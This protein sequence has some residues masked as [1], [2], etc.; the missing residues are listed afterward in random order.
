M[1]SF[2]CYKALVGANVV[3]RNKSVRR[4]LI[5]NAELPALWIVCRVS[6]S[7]TKS[8]EVHQ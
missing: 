5:L 8:E 1:F 7:K 3:P 6:L 2:I 4:R